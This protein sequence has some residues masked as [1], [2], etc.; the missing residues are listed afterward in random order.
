MIAGSLDELAF[1]ELPGRRAADPLPDA[2][3]HG[4]TVRV[5]EVSEQRRSPHVHPDCAELIHVLSG[6][7]EHW[8]AGERRF[9]TVGDVVLVPAGVAHVTLAAPVAPTTPLRLLCV[10]PSEGMPQTAEL[11]GEEVRFGGR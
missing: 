3:A 2:A 11:A 1:R 4:V 9:V 5:V 10:F 6:A 8:Q 7:G